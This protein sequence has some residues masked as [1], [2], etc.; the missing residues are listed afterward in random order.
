MILS[1][2]ACWL[3]ESERYSELLAYV[4]RGCDLANIIVIYLILG[5]EDEC[6]AMVVGDSFFVRYPFSCCIDISICNAWLLW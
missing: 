3:I 6:E 5:F 2:F 4:L 1:N